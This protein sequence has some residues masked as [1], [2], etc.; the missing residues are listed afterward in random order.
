[1][2]DFQNPDEWEIKVRKIDD[3]TSEMWYVERFKVP[4]PKE[5][6]ENTKKLMDLM[7]KSTGLEYE[8]VSNEVSDFGLRLKGTTEIIMSSLASEFLGSS[9]YGKMKLVELMTLA[10]M[11]A[12]QWKEL[13]GQMPFVSPPPQPPPPANGTKSDAI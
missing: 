11:G 3:K 13:F 1:M 9:T 2:F 12:M 8:V 7:L 10:G 6:F 4:P 5:A